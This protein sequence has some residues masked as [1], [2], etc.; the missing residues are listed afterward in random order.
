MADQLPWSPLEEQLLRKGLDLQCV[1][2]SPYKTPEAQKP[3]YFEDFL[4]LSKYWDDWNQIVKSVE[5]F[6]I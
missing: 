3:D 6:S 5:L 4:V 1:S 2:G